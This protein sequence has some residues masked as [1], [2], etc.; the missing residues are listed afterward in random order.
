MPRRRICG[1][2]SHLLSRSDSVTE[3]ISLFEAL[4]IAR[5]AASASAGELSHLL[6]PFPTK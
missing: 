1:R 6:I 4:M 5:I 3:Q 2:T